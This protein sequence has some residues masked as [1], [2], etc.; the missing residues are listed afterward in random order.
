MILDKTFC[1]IKKHNEIL[2]LCCYLDQEYILYFYGL[3]TNQIFKI[4]E[5]HKQFVNYISIYHSLY[6]GRELFKAEVS[7]ITNQFY[8]QS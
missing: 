2:V 5:H 1:L 3:D 6:L 8:I 7:N 4:I